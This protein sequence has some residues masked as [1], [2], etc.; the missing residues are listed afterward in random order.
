[1]KLKDILTLGIKGVSERKFRTALTVLSVVIGIAAIVALTSLVSGISVSISKSLESIGPSAIFLTSS[2][3]HIFTN[4]DIAE[5]ESLPN[6]SVAIPIIRFSANVT[7]GGVQQTATVYGVS[8][9]VLANALGSINLN[10]GTVYND[11]SLPTALVGYDIAFPSSTQSTSSVSINQPIYLSEHVPGA[12]T[13]SITLIPTGILN[14]YGSSL[15]LSPDTSIFIP[16]Q[17]AI[18]ITGKYSYNIILVEAKN[19]SSVAALSALLKNIYG[20]GV[21]I[22]SVE[23]IASTVS[24]II[25]SI[26]ILLGSIAGIS[27]IVAGISILSIMMVSVTERTREIG[28]LKAIGFKKKDVLILFLSEALIIGILGG[29]V[30]VT[31][32]AGASYILPTLLSG[33]GS[34]SGA[35]AGAPSAGSAGGGFATGG[36]GGSFTGRSTGGG[37]VVSG[38]SSK[39]STSSSTSSS[40][41]SPVITPGIVILAIFIAVIVSILSSLYPAWKAASVDPVKAIRSE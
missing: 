7:T 29:I 40:S 30:G 4:A 5:I 33:A 32:G 26:G 39:A 19:T 24:S 23:A 1:M 21:G 9:S 38:S 34:S 35:G 12:G 22:L 31:V 6:V 10:S 41:F 3:S 20:N 14:Q 8:N 28:I 37:A 15:L 36:G 27:L 18:S 13:K 17:N 11:S 16:L 2:P 25:G